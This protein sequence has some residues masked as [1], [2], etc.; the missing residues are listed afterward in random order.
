MNCLGRAGPNDSLIPK[1]RI[2][3]FQISHE[4]MDGGLDAGAAARLWPTAQSYEL[5]GPER[6]TIAQE[7]DAPERFSMN[8]RASGSHEADTSAF[9]KRPGSMD[10][11]AGDAITMFVRNVL[12]VSGLLVILG[13][14]ILAWI[15]PI[16]F[17]RIDTEQLLDQYFIILNSCLWS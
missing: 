1:R 5:C 3:S 9:G 7:T 4:S 8:K 16:S 13:M 15:L 10:N 6:N 12:H 2:T 17:I 11:S 14:E